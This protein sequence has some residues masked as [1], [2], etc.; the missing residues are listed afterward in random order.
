MTLI[1]L[2]AAV[3]EMTASGRFPPVRLLNSETFGR[4]LLMKEAVKVPV[5]FPPQPVAGFPFL[6]LVSLSKIAAS[7]NNSFSPQ[8]CRIRYSLASKVN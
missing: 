8:R 2:R 1:V 4:P 5:R 3:K 6:T 7:R